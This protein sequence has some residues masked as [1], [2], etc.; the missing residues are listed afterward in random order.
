MDVD[1]DGDSLEVRRT[2]GVGRFLGRQVGRRALAVGA[3]A[4]VADVAVTGAVL[5]ALAAVPTTAVVV[6][7]VVVVVVEL[8]D[9]VVVVVVVVMV[10]VV[11]AVHVAGVDGSADVMRRPTD[12]HGRKGICAEKISSIVLDVDKTGAGSNPLRKH[13]ETSV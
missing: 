10:V 6:V 3:G 7:V 1:W 2:F 13:V 12:A 5:V 4:V 8:V 11:I 9:D